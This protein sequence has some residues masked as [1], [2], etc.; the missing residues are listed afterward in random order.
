[1]IHLKAGMNSQLVQ[2][3]LVCYKFKMFHSHNPRAAGHSLP[4]LYR[5]QETSFALKAHQDWQCRMKRKPK[6]SSP[7]FLPLIISLQFPDSKMHV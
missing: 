1:M 7:A 2:W 3:E 5:H 4:K 6:V